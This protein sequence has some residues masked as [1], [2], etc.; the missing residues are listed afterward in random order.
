MYVIRHDNKIIGFNTRVIGLHFIMDDLD[1]PPRS[2]EH[3][4]RMIL[5]CASQ[6]SN[7]SPNG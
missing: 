7:R 2:T 6:F 1:H 5:S 4:P 3:T